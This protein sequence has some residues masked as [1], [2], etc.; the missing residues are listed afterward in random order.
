L[1]SE[2]KTTKTSKSLRKLWKRTALYSRKRK[3]R[4]ICSKLTKVQHPQLTLKSNFSVLKSICL[5]KLRFPQLEITSQTP[6]TE[7]SK[8]WM[9]AST[10][11]FMTSIKNKTV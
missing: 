2:L 7:T 3:P 5:K 8:P 10:K 9:R 11:L 1:R 4:G 6:G